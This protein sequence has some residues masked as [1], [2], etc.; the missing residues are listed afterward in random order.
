[1]AVCGMHDLLERNEHIK[2][3]TEFNPLRL[4]KLGVKSEKYL[5]LLQSLFVLYEIDEKGWKVELVDVP[6]FLGTYTVEKKNSTNLLCKR[7]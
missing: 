5:E 1:M 2:I 7:K 6:K 3:I 4:E